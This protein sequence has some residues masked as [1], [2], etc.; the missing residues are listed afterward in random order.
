[1]IF[2]TS[3]IL[4]SLFLFSF[5]KTIMNQEIWTFS[6]MIR[7]NSKFFYEK[8]IKSY[9]NMIIEKFVNAFNKFVKKIKLIDII[10]FDINIYWNVTSNISV[11][12]SSIFK[13]FMLLSDFATFRSFEKFKTD[14]RMRSQNIDRFK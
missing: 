1:M 12:S 3:A 10:I 4:R 2:L 8:I 7:E 13:S 6:A 11:A 9:I 14:T 5:S